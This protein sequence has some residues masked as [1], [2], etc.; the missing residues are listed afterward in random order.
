MRKR[1]TMMAGLLVMLVLSWGMAGQ[2][3]ETPTPEQQ[4]E[5]TEA[6]MKLAA[7]GAE[8]QRLAML[9][10][11]WN[12]EVKMW[13][14]PGAEPMIMTGTGINE[15]ILGGR[16]LKCESTSG[17]GEMK[18]DNLAIL[19]FDNQTG[20]YI[21]VVFDTWAT[22]YGTAAGGWNDSTKTIV[23][24][25]ESYDGVM[26]ITQQYEMNYRLID[27]DKYAFEMIYK[28]KEMTGG[29]PEFKMVEGTYSR[30][31]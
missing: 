31:K 18:Y 25:G 23:M 7:P 28:N 12:L 24:C 13:P 20:K 10:G 26:K 21:V 3:Q 29:A 9:A 1:Q 2:A 30:V 22:Y 16:F 19:G 4:A 6:Y 8:H 15:M 14:G 27:N 5:I 11:N 17:E